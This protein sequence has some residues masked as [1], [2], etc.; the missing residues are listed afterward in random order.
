MAGRLA[1]PLLTALLSLLL[2]NP[3]QAQKTP[4]FRTEVDQVVVY[5]SV[6][7]EDSQLVTGLAPDEFTL[8]ED[9]LEQEITSFAQMDV[10][11]TVGIVVDSSGSMRNKMGKVEEAMN[12]FLD[13]NNPEN[14]MF[15]VRFDDEVELE[16]D[17][18]QEVEDIRDAIGNIVVRGGTA[19]YDSI[20][21]SVEK[22]R[23]GN[24]SRRVVVVFTDGEDKDS[25]YTHEELLEKVRESEAQIFIVAFLDSELSDKKGFFGIFKSEKSKIEEQINS[26]AD[27]TG[28]RAFFPKQVD[29]L[30]PIF[31]TIA[32]DLKNQY[33]LAYISNNPAKSGEWRRIDVKVDS[34]KERKLKVRAKKGYYAKSEGVP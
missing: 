15:L 14:E 4:R 2:N 7:D 6:Y 12:L 19:L 18:T 10:P 21:L 34:A 31:E 25:Y 33:R 16:E 1:T 28:G 20:F 30:N 3:S 32:H 26:I 11:S 22:S 5:V 8:F 9:K 17:F 29:E 23:K 24:E 13:Q 27:V